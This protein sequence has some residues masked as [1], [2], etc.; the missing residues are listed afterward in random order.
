MIDRFIFNFHIA[1]LFVGLLVPF[2]GNRRLL[3]SYSLIIPFLFFHW[4]INDDT[5]ALTQLECILTNEPKERTFMGRLIG[6]IYNVSD[7]DLGKIIKVVFFVLW[8]FV[9]WRLGVIKEFI[10][11]K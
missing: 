5:C 10:H 4:S 2:V 7:N 9:Q 3:M 6:P 11:K 1:I 8:I